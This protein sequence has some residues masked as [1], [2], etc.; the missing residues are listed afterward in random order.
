M[1]R[2]VPILILFT[3][4][5]IMIAERFMKVPALGK[6]ATDIRTWGV[7]LSGFALAVS[8]ANLFVVHFGKIKAGKNTFYSGVLLV[9]MVAMAVL[10]IFAGTGSAAYKSIYN[11]ALVPMNATMFAMLAFYIA[12][13]AYRAFVARK[14]EAAVLLVSAII[15]M[16][17]NVPLGEMIYPNYSA[18]S[19]WVMNVPNL[20]AQRGIMIGSAI[21]AIT[22]SL[23]VLVGIDRTHFGGGE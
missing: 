15:V 10:G 23:R 3:T 11:A 17:D 9:A 19:N 16:L 21:G 12:S 22:I 6:I 18:I 14:I 13:A 7:V 1:R 4:G 2:E 8:A 5:L 20:A